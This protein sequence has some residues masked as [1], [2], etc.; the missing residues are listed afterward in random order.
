M[1]KKWNE[2]AREREKDR[3]WHK[4]SKEKMEI[5]TITVNRADIFRKLLSY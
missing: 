5:Y 4:E 3:V 2:R 1:S